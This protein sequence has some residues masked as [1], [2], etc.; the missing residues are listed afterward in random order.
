MPP[1]RAKCLRLQP[2]PHPSVRLRLG[3]HPRRRAPCACAPLEPDCYFPDIA[4]HAPR[5]QPALACCCPRYRRG[6]GIP[7]PNV[8]SD[9]S[10][11]LISGAGTRSPPR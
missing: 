6:A 10:A 11:N 8:R 7:N 9:R 1:R 5:L 3:W 2:H 4:R